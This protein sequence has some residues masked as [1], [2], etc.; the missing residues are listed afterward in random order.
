MGSALFMTIR[1]EDLALC[2]FQVVIRCELMLISNL[3]TFIVFCCFERMNLKKYFIGW[4]DFFVKD[5][6]CKSSGV[7]VGCPSFSPTQ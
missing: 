2:F 5:N 4:L 3:N 7:V 6:L 1:R